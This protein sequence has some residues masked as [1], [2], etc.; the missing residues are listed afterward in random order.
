MVKQQVIVRL[1]PA[2]HAYVQREAE[3][4]DR[5]LSGVVRRLV[6]E[7]ARRAQGQQQEQGA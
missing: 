1:D 7:A 4:E 5:S 2:L 6:A 3:R